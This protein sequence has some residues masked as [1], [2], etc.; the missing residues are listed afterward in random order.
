[1]GEVSMALVGAGAVGC[2]YGGRL[3][4]AGEDVSFLF[5]GGY[6]EVCERGAISGK[7]LDGDFELKSPK[8]FQS[9]EEIG[10]VD[11]VIVAW[12]ATSNAH[13][14]EVIGPLLHEETV[15][16]TLQNGLGNTEKLAELFGA[17]RVLGGLCFVCINALSPGEVEHSGGGKVSLGEFRGGELAR[18][19]ALAERFRRAGV[20]CQVESN[21]GHAQWRKL[22]WNVPFNGLCITEGGI[23]TKRLLAGE[24]GE[25]RVRGLMAEVLQGASALGYEIEPSFVEKMI[26]VT[27]SMGAYRPSSMID[28]VEGRAVEVEQIWREPLRRAK[29]RGV[30]L[31]TWEVLLG[32]IEQ[33]LRERDA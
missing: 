14:E 22:V 31:P 3:A 8:V 1:M 27:H 24:E 25:S 19:E 10:P 7:S 26:S 18:V 12:K 9:A 30:S 5:R 29:E 28:F 4:M 32:E 13:Y 20:Q 11:L 16:L 15:I 2:Y 23:D 17:E 33:R 21:L 6:E